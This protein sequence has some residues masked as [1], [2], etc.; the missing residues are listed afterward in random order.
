MTA[1]TAA[2]YLEEVHRTMA[3]ETNR[4]IGDMPTKFATLI[5]V[6]TLKCNITPPYNRELILATA[7]LSKLG[8]DRNHALFASDAA[9]QRSTLLYFNRCIPE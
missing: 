1:N 3:A 6:R 9:G 8:V 4:R 7:H 5:A 2:G